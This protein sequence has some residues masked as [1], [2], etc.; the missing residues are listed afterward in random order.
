MHKKWYIQGELFDLTKKRNKTGTSKVGAI[1]KA[2]KGQKTFFKKN[3]QKMSHRAGKCESG[4]LWA[5]ITNIL[6][7]NIEK[8][9][10]GDSFET[11]KY[12]QKKLHNAKKIER[13]PFSLVR[14][15]RLR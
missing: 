1:S 2:Q 10:K 6:L 5:L 12:F 8:T 11:L 13:G 15:C 7:Q 3:F 9:R 14:F 4:I